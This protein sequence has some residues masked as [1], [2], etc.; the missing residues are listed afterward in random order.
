M[1]YP[2]AKK[3]SNKPNGKPEIMCKLHNIFRQRAERGYQKVE[4][5]AALFKSFK[6]SAIMTNAKGKE[7][8]GCAKTG[9]FALL[10]FP[11]GRCAIF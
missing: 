7:E 9:S 3:L 11:L 4:C 10:I 1:V 2:T 6:I 5:L 8:G